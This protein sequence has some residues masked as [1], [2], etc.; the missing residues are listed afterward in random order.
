MHPCFSPC[1]IDTSHTSQKNFG[2]PQFQVKSQAASHKS[3]MHRSLPAASGSPAVLVEDA[4]GQ[5]CDLLSMTYDANTVHY[6]KPVANCF[7]DQFLPLFLHQ[8][9][10]AL[11]YHGLWWLGISSDVGFKTLGANSWCRPVTWSHPKLVSIPLEYLRMS[12]G[13][14]PFA[15]KP[16]T[17]APNTLLHCRVH[18][19]MTV[20]SQMAHWKSLKSFAHF[21]THVVSSLASCLFVFFDVL[22]QNIQC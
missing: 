12:H 15:R 18:M 21:R 10:I 1:P 16:V 3:H 19:R 11:L 22:L 8:K 17:K 4:L 13:Y 5:K 9:K 14:V 7:T 2:V 20:S 6:G